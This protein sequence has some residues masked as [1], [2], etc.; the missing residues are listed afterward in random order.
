MTTEKREASAG[1]RLAM[2]FGPLLV[3]FLANFLA[4]GEPKDKIFVATGAFM[5]A[6]AIAMIFSKLKTGRVSAM[7]LFSGAMV[8]VLGGAAIV[9]HNDVFIKMKPTIYYGLIAAILFFGLATGKPMLKTVLG[10]SYPGLTERGWTILTRNWAIFFVAAG[11]LN[12][13]VWRNVET[14]TWLTFKVFGMIPI[15]LLFAGSQIPMLLRNGMG[16]KAV[17]DSPPIPPGN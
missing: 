15:T 12:E 11:C 8:L 9:F 17:E 5:V 7:Q 2:D 10:S 14:S 3:F 4:P 13:A 1:L 6:T 16:E